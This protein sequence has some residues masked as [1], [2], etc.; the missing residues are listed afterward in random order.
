[1]VKWK[2]IA[3][4]ILTGGLFVVGT[5]AV[6]W[7]AKKV[8]NIEIPN[9]FKNIFGNPLNNNN[10]KETVPKPKLDFL[11][12]PIPKAKLPSFIPKQPRPKKIKYTPEYK[13]LNKKKKQY[14]P[15]TPKLKVP[16]GIF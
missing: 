7:I 1:L 10:M 13:K 2:Y 8:A 16:G 3:L 11:K 5:Y 4:T 15:K 12:Q 6:E 14:K 9:P